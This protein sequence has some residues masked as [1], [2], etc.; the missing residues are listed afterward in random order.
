MIID[1]ETNE[2]KMSIRKRLDSEISVCLHAFTLSRF[3]EF[4]EVM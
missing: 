2:K 1:R 4:T 3:H